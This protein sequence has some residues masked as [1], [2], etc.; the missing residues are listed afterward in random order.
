MR[1]KYNIR[2]IKDDYSYSVEQVADLFGVDVGTV[3]RWIR[4]EGLKRI[5]SIR[6]HLIHSSELREFHKLEQA[7]RKKPC[8]SYEVFCFRCQLARTPKMGSA[9]IIHLPNT[10]VRL[11]ALCDECG[12][13]M[14]RS[15]RGVEWTPNHPLA[16]YLSGALGAHNR[17][18][19]THREC[20]FQLEDGACQNT[21]P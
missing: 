11:H 1:R 13:K 20:A 4:V 19:L 2:L 12:G 21:T 14:N 5:A 8:A 6:P 3:R 9:T 7:K 15:I 10:S 17:A 16:A 18:Q